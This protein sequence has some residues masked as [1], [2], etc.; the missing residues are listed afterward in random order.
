MSILKR[1]VNSYSDFL[2]IFS[3]ITHNLSVNFKLMY[4]LL[5]AKGSRQ[6]PN[7]DTSKCFGENLPNSSCNFPSHKPAFLQILHDSTVSWKI[8]DLYFLMSKLYNLH[9]RDQSKCK[10][11]R[12]LS[13]RS[14]F[15]KFFTFLKQQSRFSSNFTSLFSVM[16]HN[17][18][19]NSYL[20]FNFI[21]TFFFVFF[22]SIKPIS[23]WTLKTGQKLSIY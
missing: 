6:S 22:L 20:K 11:L 15:T 16:R 4:F 10:F 21:Y 5:W 9:E 1:Q 19:V 23:I 18:S 14:K 2:S 12:I 8:T 7:F 3:L 13:A 17:S